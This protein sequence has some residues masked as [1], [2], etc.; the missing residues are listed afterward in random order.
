MVC[1]HELPPSGL[2]QAIPPDPPR[3]PSLPQVRW[4]LRA[5]LPLP[6][7]DVALALALVAYVQRHNL[8][9]Y[10]SHHK[11]ALQRLAAQGP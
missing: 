5:A 10:R 6:V 3:I 11:R 9:A 1:L 8:A 4:L 2:P 7:L